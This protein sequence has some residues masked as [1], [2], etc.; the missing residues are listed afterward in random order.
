MLA[1]SGP[2]DN[3]LRIS[4]VLHPSLVDLVNEHPAPGRR[5]LQH[6]LD[7]SIPEPVGKE[8]AQTGPG[9][10][11]DP[12]D[13][14]E[15]DSIAFRNEDEVV[16]SPQRRLDPRQIAFREVML[17]PVLVYNQAFGSKDLSHPLFVLDEGAP[18]K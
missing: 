7:I 10:T 6:Q 5:S 12:D 9:P 13:K 15:L 11:V 3:V 16:L 18:V 2:E 14:G 17:R 8:R 1:L 4:V